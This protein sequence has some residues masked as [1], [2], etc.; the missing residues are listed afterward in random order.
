MVVFVK[1]FILV[2]RREFMEMNNILELIVIYLLDYEIIIVVCY[3][4]FGEMI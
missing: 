2:V 1:N 4:K 3:I